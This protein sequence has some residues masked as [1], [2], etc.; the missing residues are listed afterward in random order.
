MQMLSSI[1]NSEDLT[2]N[3]NIRQPNFLRD[4]VQLGGTILIKAAQIKALHFSGQK[5]Y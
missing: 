2:D 3:K 5:L 1:K 4:L